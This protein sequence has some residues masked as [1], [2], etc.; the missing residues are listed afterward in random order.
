[1]P[2]IYYNLGRRSGRS[3][4]ATIFQGAGSMKNITEADLTPEEL[5][6]YRR[7]QELMQMV[8]SPVAEADKALAAGVGIENSGKP[9]PNVTLQVADGKDHTVLIVDGRGIQ[10]QPEAARNIATYLRQSA[11]RIEA[12][13][14]RRANPLKPQTKSRKRH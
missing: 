4:L 5:E 14:L 3:Y 12:E 2:Y 10:L 6:R 1:M 13:R 7:D 11:N 8:D 9:A